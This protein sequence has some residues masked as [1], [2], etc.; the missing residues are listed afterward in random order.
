MRQKK[1]ENRAKK[2]KKI[3][4]KQLKQYWLRW[5]TIL[6]GKR[7]KSFWTIKTLCRPNIEIVCL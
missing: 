2:I 5:L 6:T 7:E 3:K 4:R 1:R